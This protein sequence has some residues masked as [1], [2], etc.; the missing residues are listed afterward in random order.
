MA[1]TTPRFATT[2][3]NKDNTGRVI[4]YDFQTPAHAA[5]LA[6]APKYFDTTVKL[7][8]L[9]G[10]VTINATTTNAYAGDILKFLF[11]ADGTNRVVTF[12]TNMASTGTLTVTA[13]KKATASFI[14]NGT[15]YVESGRAIEA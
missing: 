3:E 5:T 15:T 9:T 10:A 6:V 11:I 8:E 2:P 14:F 12:G 7:A 4:T 1:S 13:S